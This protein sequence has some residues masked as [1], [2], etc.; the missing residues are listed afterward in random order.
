MKYF[1]AIFYLF[2][3]VG[4]ADKPSL[5]EIYLNNYN[6]IN[7]GLE[8]VKENKLTVFYFMA[9]E[10]PLSQNYSLQ[11]KDLKQQFENNGV[12]FFLVFS[13]KSYNDKEV[14]DFL[15]EYMLD[16]EALKDSSF[17]LANFFDATITPE[18][19]M[20]NNN[21][22]VLYSGKIDNWIESL[23]VKRQVV[24]EFYLKDAITQYLERKPIKTTKTEAV[25]CLIE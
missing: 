19:F 3:S 24:T 6:N 5:S 25:G 16:L 12:K 9:P 7:V 23:G 2:L 15:E 20:V 8:L 22:D 4:C 13:G 17:V 10:C 18:V 21:G 11:I 14:N 1:Y